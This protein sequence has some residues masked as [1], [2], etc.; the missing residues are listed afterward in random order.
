MLTQPDIERMREISRSLALLDKELGIISE[1]IAGQLYG[2]GQKLE[3]I[4]DTTRVFLD[5]IEYREESKE[6][7]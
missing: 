2:V 4:Y 5:D 7:K 6:I 3:D 1:Q